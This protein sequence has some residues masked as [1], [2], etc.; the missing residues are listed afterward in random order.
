MYF[1]IRIFLQTCLQNL[2]R[3]SPNRRDNERFPAGRLLVGNNWFADWIFPDNRRI[4][5]GM[6][7]KPNVNLDR[8]NQDFCLEPAPFKLSGLRQ[9]VSLVLS[10]VEV[11]VDFWL[12]SLHK[13]R[14]VWRR[15][16]VVIIMCG[17]LATPITYQRWSPIKD[18]VWIFPNYSV[19]LSNPVRKLQILTKY[20]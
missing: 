1:L 5:L 3:F 2:S 7:A 13:R 20:N 12:Q 15:T 18:H 6:L 10:A 14:T 19:F 4:V 9:R 8:H 17:L 16:S 11:V